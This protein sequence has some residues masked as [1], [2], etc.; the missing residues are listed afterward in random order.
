MKIRIV[1]MILTA[2]CVGAR[3]ATNE[4]YVTTAECSK[5]TT[6]WGAAGNGVSCD[7]TEL[8]VGDVTF[9]RGIG[10]HA[11]G[12]LVIPAHG[13]WRWLT[14]SMGI[15]SKMTERGSIVVEVL[16]DD[17]P[18]FKSPVMRVRE[19]PRYVEVPVTG[20]QTIRIV[21]SDAGDGNSADHADLGNLRLSASVAKPACDQPKVPVIVGCKSGPAQPLAL[22]YRQP[23]KRWLEALPVGNGRLGAMVFG[24]VQQEKLALN[25]STLWSGAPSDTN[26]NPEGQKHLAEIRQL[27]FDGKYGQA[28]SLCTQ[29]LGRKNSYGTHL[30]LADLS[31]EFQGE[32]DT[33]TDYRRQLDLVE[34]I[35]KV[36]FA[37]VRREVFASNPDNVL[38]MRV[39]CGK[40]GTLGFRV[41]LN[42][43]YTPQG[44]V[45]ATGNTL[46]FS[47]HAWE[48]AHSNG[49]TGVA[50]E[51]WVRVLAEKGSVTVVSNQLEVAGANAA[52]ILVAANTTFGGGDPAALCRQQIEAA[53]GKSYAALRRVHVADHQRLFRRVALEL[54]DDA[55]AKLPTDE[56]LTALKKGSDDAQLAA[57]FFQF[58]RYLMIAGSRENSPL[59]M[60]LQ[61]IWNDNIACRMPWTCDYHLDINQEQ[62]YWPA[63]VCNLSECHEPQFKLI[64][65]LRESG[66][67]TA[68]ELYGARGWVAHVV[69]NPW[70]YTAPGWDLGWAFH[71]T[72]GIWLANDLWQHYQFTGDKKFLAQRAYPT[73]KEAAEFFLDYMV[74]DPKTGFLCTGPAVSPENSFKAPG[75]GLF[76]EDMGPVADTVLVRELFTACIES[77]RLLGT[78]DDFRAKLET[79]RGKLQPLAVGKHGQLEE[80]RLDYDEAVPNHRHTSHLVAVYPCDQISQRRTPELAK[81]AATTIQR[82]VTAPG[83][84]DV[85]FTRG[86][87]LTFFARLGDPEAAYKQLLGLLCEDTYST[88]FTYSRGGIAGAPCDI[89]VLDGNMSGAAGIA[90]L[91]LQSNNGEI[92][93]LPAL[94]KAWPSG[95][96]TGLC[97][98]GGFTVDIE[99]KDG[100]LT[101]ARIH[102]PLG[103]VCVMRYGN[104]TRQLKLR[105]GQMEEWKL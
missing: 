73:L 60:H 5:A 47:G 80:W 105:A 38:V 87:F 21:V 11:P 25:E 48:G 51:G 6:G 63:E 71:P 81:A 29:L 41:K 23:A 13:D 27:F 52:T 83:F 97:A 37:D 70:G 19:A 100:K 93:L 68:K 8:T 85:E 12:E 1:A 67:R 28:R 56:R 46:V 42:N 98:R 99:W 101:R 50:F 57:L 3:A 43:P 74:P 10:L 16:G 82:R 61:G 78:D 104:Q 7:G 55:G 62:N 36:E 24:G 92:E 22:W 44:K 65:I 94:P 75:G 64:E 86:N 20:V 103:G 39:T 59:P 72:G 89:F 9:A 79:A 96:V 90:E 95:K 4:V 53:S 66:R 49:K 18:L 17:Q 30:P 76:F 32:F 77:S 14:F 35:A 31:V 2:L 102:A 33:V 45:E 40:P 84:E 58:G 88:M 69:T 91:L 26:V 15:N 34:G 54:G